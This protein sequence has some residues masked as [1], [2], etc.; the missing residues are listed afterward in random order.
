MSAEQNQRAYS[1]IIEKT[2]SHS[3]IMCDPQIRFLYAEILYEIGKP[4]ECLE[5]LVGLEQSLPLLK[6]S[7]F[8]FRCILY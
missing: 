5:I 8:S 3:H 7:Y 2:V 6:Q 4:D 1:L